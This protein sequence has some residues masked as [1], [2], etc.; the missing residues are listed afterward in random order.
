MDEE[1]CL[2]HFSILSSP[3]SPVSHREWNLLLLLVGKNVRVKRRRRHKRYERSVYAKGMGGELTG[4]GNRRKPRMREQSERQKGGFPPFF[5]LIVACLMLFFPSLDPRFEPL[6]FPPKKG[7]RCRGSTKKSS[8]AWPEVPS[9]LSQNGWLQTTAWETF[10]YSFP[11]PPPRTYLLETLNA[12][13][14]RMC[15]T[16]GFEKRDPA[17]SVLSLTGQPAR[18][19]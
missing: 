17:F 4:G 16:N 19:G 5:A 3:P 11:L 7:R 2:L 1:S 14:T 10:P 15:R 13:G 6:S 12:Y 18:R 8:L 9:R